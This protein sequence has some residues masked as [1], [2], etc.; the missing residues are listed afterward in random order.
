MVKI[1][2]K[3]E[4]NTIENGKNVKKI[5]KKTITIFIV[6]GIIIMCIVGYIIYE[7][8]YYGKV[9]KKPI[10]YLYPTE[11]T[12]INI[13]LGNKDNLIC[14]Y[15]SYTENGWNVL[16]KT[17]GSLTNLDN[18]RE[19]YSLYYEANNLVKF[20]VKE[21]GFIVKKDNVQEFL[22]EKLAILGLNE[23]EAEEFIVYW[24]PKLQENEYNYIRFATNEEINKNMP[25]SF[26]VEPDT[27]IRVLM[28]YKGLKFPINVKEQKLESQDRNGF[29]AVEWGGTEIK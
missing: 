23:I 1:M 18:G 24:L 2:K 11:D 4:K 13:K 17:N 29:V 27:L 21:D 5:S 15:P 20:T 6:I 12:N 25:L 22:E 9:N 26:S 14:T 3:D 8:N 19:L 7:N 10:I 28:T 16:A